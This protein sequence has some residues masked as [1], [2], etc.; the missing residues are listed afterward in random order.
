[1]GNGTRR[2]RGA[3][4]WLL[5]VALVWSSVVSP[6]QAAI[7][8]L[9][10]QPIGASGVTNVPANVLLTPS[11]EYPTAISQ[12]HIGS[13]SVGTVYLGYFDSYKCYD[14]DAASGYFVPKGW[15][16]G[17]TVVGGA[18]LRAGAMTCAGRWSGN[19]LNWATMQTIDTFRLI[20]TGGDRVVDTTTKTVVQKAYA[21]NQGSVSSNF[22]IKSLTDGV[23]QV[24]PYGTGSVHVRIWSLGRLMRIGFTTAAKV[25]D[26]TLDS[27][28]IEMNV[29]VQVCVNDLDNDAGI[30]KP[31]LESNCVAYGSGTD[32]NYKPEG[33]IQKNAKTMRFGVFAYL[34]DSSTM[35]D[36]G[37]LRARM[38]SVGPQK[39]VPGSVATVNPNAEWDAA[40]GVL[41]TNPDADDAAST[42]PAVVNS[43]VINYLNKFGASGS[44]KALDNVS[45]MYYGAIRYLRNLGS[46]PEWHDGLN[47]TMVDGFPVITNWD[48][49]IQYKCQKNFTVGI[50][51]VNTHRDRDVPG[52]TNR[53]GEPAT[54]PPLV[55][56]DPIDINAVTNALG[57]YEGLGATLGDIQ[58][59]ASAASYYIAGVAFWAHTND[60]RSD[61]SG[62]Q[63]VDFFWVDVMEGRVYRH[64]NQYWL[65]AKYGGFNDS[66][67]SGTPNLSAEWAENGGMFGTSP[68]PDNYFAAAN[69]S[70]MASGLSRTFA[71]IQAKVSRAS[72]LKLPSPILPA[73][74]EST[75]SFSPRYDPNTW[76][77]DVVGYQTSVSDDGELTNNERF[78]AKA[79]IQAAFSGSNHATRKVV[80][81]WGEGA[82]FATYPF[83]ADG[84]PAELLAALDSDMLR[85]Q[86]LVNYL[87]GDLSL[88]GTLWR[89]RQALLGSVV[90]SDVGIVAASNEP[91]DDGA[92]P[93]YSTF[94]SSTAS[95]APTVL[96]GANDGM[97]HM[98]DGDID[99]G[100]GGNELWAYVPRAMYASDPA[101]AT[102]GLVGFASTSY[103][104][105]YLVDGKIRVQDVYLQD[106]SGQTRTSVAAGW[107]TLAIVGLG[108]G[109]RAYI[110]LDVTDAPSHG[111]LSVA[112][113][114]AKVLWEF[115][116][117]GMGYTYGQPRVFKT[118]AYGWV[119]ALPSGYNNTDGKGYVFLV[120]PL[121]GQKMAT[122]TTASG[123]A[124]DPSGLAHVGAYIPDQGDYTAD[125]LY[126]GDLQ[127][128]V[129]RWDLRGDASLDGQV[130]LK[131][132]QLT[133]AAGAAIP[134]TTEPEI[135]SYPG[136]QE[137]YVFFGTGRYLDDSDIIV[138]QSQALFGLRDGD[139]Y[140]PWE[141]STLPA[142]LSYPIG[143]DELQSVG[144]LTDGITYDPDKGGWFHDLTDGT[145]GANERVIV[146]PVAYGGQVVFASLVPGSDPCAPQGTSNL[147]A[148]DFKSAAS[149]LKVP[150]ISLESAVVDVS[151]INSGGTVT[152]AVST[153][154]SVGSSGNSTDDIKCSGDS[155]LVSMR[156]FTPSMMTRL[157]VRE[158]RPGL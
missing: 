137:R 28:E 41:I 58:T 124:S 72:G 37:V 109:G 32:V 96:V 126:G 149:Q 49:P 16:A 68:L 10:D 31:M 73:Q 156:A 150:K 153:A 99:S 107:H 131:I 55:A 36:G 145:G 42:S 93:G 43:G 75:Y 101:F 130:A 8:P 50:G 112:A 116:D 76:T 106:V 151:I 113:L 108:K 63:T 83:T 152:A 84:V 147:Y 111:A 135:Q 122:L 2:L 62:T 18:V 123:T 157:S 136:T 104:H 110:A 12:A 86:S 121:T 29:A 71:Q 139:R 57:A 85:A 9:A 115:T 66:D 140:T 127:G 100:E 87:R 119:V 39:Y 21:S 11:V 7:T 69:P 102:N 30:G 77:G 3:L 114:G 38:K 6:L 53:T 46:V 52:G 103:T 59:G 133:N 79:K 4:S 54:M 65:A 61:L 48:D 138:N 82:G 26:N 132:A 154:G 13:F 129:W 97:L 24:T 146:N 74:G 148:L 80:T 1:M 17:V 45:E 15:T 60:I 90:N 20:M 78:S 141:A 44:Y 34:N 33:L 23:A 14:Y 92:N 35:R 81:G 25:Q 56:A 142:S 128:N 27:G 155:C 47:A 98:L 117:P 120:N 105:R 64:R 40:T 19:Y 91:Y 89:T 134:I 118:R 5:S 88:E 125:M 144:D 94:K 143:R 95:R 67:G 22:E 51:D 70:A 158:V